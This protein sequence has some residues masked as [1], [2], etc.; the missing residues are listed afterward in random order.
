MPKTTEILTV[1][2]TDIEVSNLGGGNFSTPLDVHKFLRNEE[3]RDQVFAAAISQS[4]QTK[5]DCDFDPY[6]LNLIG[7]LSKSRSACSKIN[8]RLK[9]GIVFAMWKEAFRLRPQ[10]EKNPHGEN[11]LLAKVKSLRWLLDGTTIDWHIF[12]IDDGCPDDSGGVARALVEEHGLSRNVSIAKLEDLLAMRTCV[13]PNLK[14]IAQ[15]EKGGAIAWGSMLAVES[16][17]D[18]VLYTDCDNSVEIAQLGLLLERSLANVSS[19]VIG[20]RFPYESYSFWHPERKNDLPG[21]KLISHLRRAVALNCV[22]PPDVPSPFKLFDAKTIMGVIKNLTIFN[23]SFD[24]DI[25]L[26]LKSSGVQIEM[27]PV[28]YLDSYEETTWN[29]LGYEK[30]LFDKLTTFVSAAK[31]HGFKVRPKIV[32]IVN[33]YIKSPTDIGVLLH[34]ELPYELQNTDDS[35]VGSLQTMS[36][37]QVENWL[38]GLGL[39]VK[40]LADHDLT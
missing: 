21:S 8:M 10:S 39:P 7:S 30:V 9:I 4:Q 12:A 31:R 18:L 36:A 28:V 26:G 11:S 3:F 15:S 6:I 35:K 27:V 16:G 17:C 37:A 14:S 1:M 25:V 24:F 2:Q 33:T 20:N 5:F 38:Q 29:S 13:V 40:A 22:L 32:K 34:A 19:V 23:F